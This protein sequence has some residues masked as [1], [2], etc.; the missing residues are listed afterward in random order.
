MTSIFVGTP[1]TD[2]GLCHINYSTSL[3]RL[4]VNAFQNNID[5]SVA[6]TVNDS[7]VTHARNC[8]AH[9]FMEHSD[10][11]T[12]LFIDSDIG[13]E[14]E[15][16]LKMVY[17]NPGFIG[18][19]FPKKNINWGLAK[20]A[21]DLGKDNIDK[22]CGDFAVVFSGQQEITLNKPTEC[23]RVGFAIVAIKRDFL[24]Q[25]KGLVRTYNDHDGEEKHEYFYTGFDENNHILSETYTFCDLVNKN[26]LKT[27]VAPWVNV[28]HAGTYLFQGSFSETLKLQND[29]T[30]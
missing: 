5:F 9:T 3:A 6:S 16:V 20:R 21:I 4:A 24:E 17:E 8:V 22:Y 23:A 30:G 25:V 19:P 11:D 29:K 18:V 14:S 12:L 27:Y 7:I 15:E 2:G 10:A 1:T 28:T 13:F 26:G